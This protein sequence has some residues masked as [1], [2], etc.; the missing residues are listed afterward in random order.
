MTIRPRIFGVDLDG[1][2]IRIAPTFALAAKACGYQ[3]ELDY[4]QYWMGIPP[5]LR[6]PVQ[7]Y[8]VVS[9]LIQTLPA[10]PCAAAAVKQ[11]QDAGHNVVFVT[12]RGR[13][14][15]GTDSDLKETIELITYQWLADNNFSVQRPIIFTADKRAAAQDFGI[16][17][18]VEDCLETAESFLGT[19]IKCYLVDRPWNGGLY[20]PFGEYDYPWRI[21]LL[22]DLLALLE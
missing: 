4:T 6:T 11:L 20:I 21:R 18:M 3:E 13:G 12:A 9:G 2:C 1:V 5:N 7:N 14:H 19:D 22:T 10:Y 8:M 17:V 15:T 16:D